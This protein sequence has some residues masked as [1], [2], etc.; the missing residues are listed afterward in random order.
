MVEK[1]IEIR[2]YLHSDETRV[3]QLWRD[4]GLVMEWNNPEN[5]IA[6]KLAVDPDLFIVGE[7]DGEVVAT[8]MGGYEGHRGWINYLAVV[9]TLQRSGYGRDM[10]MAVEERLKEKGCPKIN[11]QVRAT[12]KNVIQFYKSLGFKLDD[13]VSMGK[14]LVE[15]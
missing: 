2:I 8:V 10:M 11:L 12:N 13:V 7:V 15:D 3:V 4:C 6:R 9:P 1:K 14:R 5:D